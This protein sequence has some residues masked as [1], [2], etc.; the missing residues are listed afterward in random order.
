MKWK[1]TSLSRVVFFANPWTI[2]S[3]EFSRP[4]HWN[5]QMFPSP[6]DLPNP[7]IEPRSPTL[8]VDSLPAEPQERPRILE[9]VA[10]TF[11]RESS[12]PR[13]RTG[14]SCIA[15]RFFT[16][17]AIREARVWSCK[18]VLSSILSLIYLPPR[19]ESIAMF[20]V[21]KGSPSLPHS[22]AHEYD[23]FLMVI[24]IQKR[25]K[26]LTWGWLRKFWKFFENSLSLWYL[27]SI[28]WA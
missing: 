19:W 16:N 2:Q 20:Q 12:Q 26:S 22:M 6:G 15:G 23:R 14:V 8:R 11:S 24:K 28:L 17:W 18:Y 1:W 9:W 7:G 25:E 5:E 4:E 10:Y 3:M 27:L 21:I 13:S